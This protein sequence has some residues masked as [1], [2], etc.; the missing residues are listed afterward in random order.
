MPHVSW[1]TMGIA[2]AYIMILIQSPV[3]WCVNG[4]RSFFRQ[5]HIREQPGRLS[6]LQRQICNLPNPNFAD[7]A[8]LQYLTEPKEAPAA[9]Q[10][11][12]P[13]I[14]MHLRRKSF[15]FAGFATEASFCILHLL[16]RLL[17]GL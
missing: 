2:V 6:F 5:L 4:R 8:N 17:E 13:E 3:C 16:Q 12:S 7:E 1:L 10:D 9:T 14:G 11:H 15:R